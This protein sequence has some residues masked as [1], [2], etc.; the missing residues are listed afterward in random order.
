MSLSHRKEVLPMGILVVDDLEDNRDLIIELLEEKEYSNLHI[1]EG[2]KKAIE[3]LE[4]D[5][6]IDLV[7]LDINMP[8]VSGYEVL[9]YIQSNDHLKTIPVVMVTAIDDLNSVI[10]CVESGAED[11]L[12]KPVEEALLWARVQ[13]CLERK[14]LRNKEREL[15]QQVETEKRKSEKVLYNVLPQSVAERLKNGEQTIAES[16]P[17]VTVIFADLVGFTKLSADISPDE[18]VMLLNHI[19]RSFDRI[20]KKYNLEKIKTIGDAYMAAGGISPYTENH[21]IRCL[22]M[23]ID[24]LN[25]IEIFNQNSDIKLSIRI[26]LCT[27]PVVAGV[28][29]STRFSYDLW[30]DTVNIASRMQALS[31]PNWIQVAEST[32]NLLEKLCPFIFRGDIDVKGKGTMKSYLFSKE[33]FDSKEKYASCKAKI[34]KLADSTSY[35]VSC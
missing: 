28:I 35:G 22:A 29:G 25:I 16:I 26:G 13:A 15:F 17:E 19:F 6:V 4:S 31:I 14:Y 20:V 1:A 3:I 34:M 11:Y 24:A 23:S 32:H 30:G 2:G 33:L 18:L 21:A 5:T 9:E 10:R 8:I 27:G 12:V 7:L